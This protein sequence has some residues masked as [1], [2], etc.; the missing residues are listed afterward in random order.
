M[1]EQKRKKDAEEAAR[2]KV[3]E[4]HEGLSQCLETG[5]KSFAAFAVEKAD[6]GITKLHACSQCGLMFWE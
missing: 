1:G 3:P 4:L 5:H 6:T 2:P